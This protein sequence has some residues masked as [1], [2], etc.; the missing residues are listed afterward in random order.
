[1]PAIMLKSRQASATPTLIPLL[2]PALPGVSPSLPLPAAA[3]EP[4]W[5]TAVTSPRTL[6]RALSAFAWAAAPDKPSGAASAV[7]HEKPHRL[8]LSPPAQRAAAAA[9]L[10]LRTGRMVAAVWGASRAVAASDRSRIPLANCMSTVHVPAVSHAGS[11]A[12]P[13][14]GK[15]T[16]SVR[17]SSPS[18]RSLQSSSPVW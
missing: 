12:A 11:T 14:S 16:S 10:V 9:A 3:A 17:P 8:P 6:T 13:P 18:M 5:V 4:S 1:M 15:K 2:A 7:V